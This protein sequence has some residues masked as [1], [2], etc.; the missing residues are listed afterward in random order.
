MIDMEEHE[1]LCNKYLQDRR[2]VKIKNDETDLS[3]ILDPFEKQFVRNKAWKVM[4]MYISKKNEMQKRI[5]DLILS[6]KKFRYIDVVPKSYLRFK[7]EWKHEIS[8]KEIEPQ[9]IKRLE[10]IKIKKEDYD[11]YYQYIKQDFDK[12]N[13]MVS[14]RRKVYEKQKSS[15]QDKKTDHISKSMS[16][17]AMDEEEKKVY[18]EKRAYYDEQIKK[19]Q[20]FLDELIYEENTEPIEYEAFVELLTNAAKYYA[21]WDIVR[22][23]KIISILSPNL[24]INDDKT[25]TIRVKSSLEWLFHGMVGDEGFEPTTPS[26]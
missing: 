14:Q 8:Y 2:W 5:D 11:A 1:I 17:G 21:L 4:S 15:L 10:W 12:K 18:M 7:A 25:V 23:R 9:I 19:V 22:R 3:F 20:Q 6:W 13:E 16:C 26:V 24:I